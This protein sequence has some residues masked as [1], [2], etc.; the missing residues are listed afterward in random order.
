MLK[1]RQ[2]S[3]A[4]HSSDVP[5][6][7]YRMATTWLM[8]SGAEAKN[9]VAWIN[10]ATKRSPELYLHNVVINCHGKPGKLYVGGGNDYIF[11]GQLGVFKNIQR[12]SVGTIYIVACEVSDDPKGIIW[13]SEFCTKLSVNSGC[14]VVAPDQTQWVDKE[15]N[16]SH[17]FGCIDDYEGPVWE[18]WPS[19]SRRSWKPSDATG[20]KN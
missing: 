15:F 2:P 11:G 19:G 17:P 18:Y 10:M 12:G 8:P 16:S 6:Y 20:V 4:L 7:K 1:L 9:V 3:L 14:F 13:G 5:G